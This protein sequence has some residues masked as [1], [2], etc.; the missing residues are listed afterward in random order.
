MHYDWPD[1]ALY[2]GLVE[3]DP[4]AL[5]ALIHRYSREMSYFIR[6]VLDGVGTPQDAEECA[7]DLFVA[8]WQ[9]IGT[10]DPARG[11]LRTWVTMRGKYIALDR[12]RQVQRRQAAFTSLDAG[13][14]AMGTH[15]ETKPFERPPASLTENSMEGQLE[16]R[17]RREELRRALTLLPELD[18]TLVYMRYWQ[19]ASTEAICRKTGLTRHAIDTRLW[20][21]RKQLRDA[22]EE[23]AHGRVGAQLDTRA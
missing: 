17:E 8:V 3:R 15:S 12:R 10:F 22:L 2:T 14:S 13:E 6:L 4:R 18:R 7:N 9:E 23:Q 20:R 1:D 5:E 21:A 16:Q 11:S 19:L